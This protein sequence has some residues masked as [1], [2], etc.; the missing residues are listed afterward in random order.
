MT[1][2]PCKRKKLNAIVELILFVGWFG[3]VKTRCEEVKEILTG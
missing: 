1:R 2:L 3:L